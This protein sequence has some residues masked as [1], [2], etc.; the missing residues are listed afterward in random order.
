MKNAISLIYFNKNMAN[1]FILYFFSII[2]LSGLSYS[3]SKNDSNLDSLL[4]I[5]ATINEQKEKIDFVNDALN[6]N[7]NYN[8]RRVLD[9]A[10]QNLATANLEKYSKGIAE[11]YHIIGKA[12]HIINYHQESDSI[13]RLAIDIYSKENLF[14]NII[15]AHIDRTPSLLE[16]KKLD[17][18]E[19]ALNSALKLAEKYSEYWIPNIYQELGRVY[20]QKNDFNKAVEYFNLALNIYT[21]QNNTFMYPYLRL[22]IALAYI[23]SPN[24]D[25]ARDY[26][27]KA[28]EEFKIQNNDLYVA[29]TYKA[30]GDIDNKNGNNEDAAQ[31]YL[32]S[33]NIYEKLKYNYGMMEN[34][35][36]LYNIEIKR[37]NKD[38]SNKYLEKYS[39]LLKNEFDSNSLKKETER[40]I[41]FERI[42]KQLA[43]KTI[44]DKEHQLGI[45]QLEIENQK[46]SILIFVI[47]SIL[48]LV[49]AVILYLMFKNKKKN[50]LL[51]QK[52]NDELKQKNILIDLQKRDIEEKNRNILDSIEYAQIIQKS[53]L[54]I[55]NDDSKFLK[56]H[57]QLFIPKDIVSG[58]F[59]WF[60]ET[61]DYAYVAAIDCTGHGVPGAFMSMIGNTMLNE[62]VLEKKIY[63]PKQILGILNLKIRI[64]LKQDKEASANDGMD[65]ALVRFDKK[66]TKTMIFAGAKRP[67]YLVGDDANLIEIKG[68]K[69]SIG[70]RIRD[71]VN[72][73]EQHKLELT[74][75]MMIYLST[76]GFADQ[77]NPQNKKYGTKQLKE[78]LSQ[79]SK[80]DI[81]QQYKRLS[82]EF[83]NHKLSEEQRDDVT[84][85]GIRVK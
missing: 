6:A 33:Y 9:L 67:V 21:E 29:K 8:A 85:I 63:E 72:D 62:I 13:I 71:V 26:L 59:Y 14:E 16:L 45:S 34:M 37:N 41:T 56:E 10:N 73:F 57:F 61:A 58:D 22:D 3:N 66:N 76:D 78:L 30:E 20:S 75:N 31:N 69:Q 77:N 28:R 70:G 65:M 17:D 42:Q 19:T 51:L 12:F 18:A 60:A 83:E 1:R 81:E 7:I 50:N 68:D 11:S 40:Q 4:K 47:S 46:L 23:N 74:S 54:Q 35:L 80:Q 2:L 48:L 24:P 64:A 52:I 36:D 15:E 82:E 49:I 32:K 84:I 27:T 39:V 5:S 25:L 43:K 38:L 55:D 44:G 79:I 53:I